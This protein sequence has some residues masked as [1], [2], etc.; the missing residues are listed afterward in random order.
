M[1]AATGIFAG[2]VRWRPDTAGG[3]EGGLTEADR[4]CGYG[5]SS[6]S[7]SQRLI[8]VLA[9]RPCLLKMLVMWASMVRS[10][11]N[12][13]AAICLLLRLSATSWATSS[14]LRVSTVRGWVLTAGAGVRW[15][16]SVRAANATP[17]AIVSARPWAEAASNAPF[18]RD[19]GGSARVL[20]EPLADGPGLP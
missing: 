5:T 6:A 3:L 13:L 19:N 10:D 14:S 12:R 2:S 7:V 11:R 9:L 1:W 15:S 18:G 16:R 8:W 20:L 4:V 17:S